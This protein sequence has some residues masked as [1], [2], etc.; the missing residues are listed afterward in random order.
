MGAFFMAFEDRDVE[1]STSMKMTG[2][3]VKAISIQALSSSCFVVLDTVGDVHLLCLSYSV[4]GLDKHCFMKRLT[5][6]MKV[7]NLAVF[8]DVSTGM[9]SSFLLKF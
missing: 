4:Q 8:H 7:L 2:R 9:L 6:T 5:Q 3:S 1:S